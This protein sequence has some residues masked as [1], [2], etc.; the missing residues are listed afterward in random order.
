MVA[1]LHAWIQCGKNKAH[2][3][4]DLQPVSRFLESQLRTYLAQMAEI[5]LERATLST[6]ATQETADAIELYMQRADLQTV[7]SDRRVVQDM[8]K[9]LLVLVEKR[10]GNFK[11]T[12]DP[13]RDPK[14]PSGVDSLGHFVAVCTRQHSR[15]RRIRLADGSW[16]YGLRSRS[17]STRSSRSCLTLSATLARSS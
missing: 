6:E 10:P 3:V 7:R 12:C 16:L 1:D 17:L 15:R 4:E 9:D 11:T 14:D 5:C 13:K 2:T 8:M